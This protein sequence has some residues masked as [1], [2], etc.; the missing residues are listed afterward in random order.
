MY[1]Y[2]IK[3]FACAVTHFASFNTRRCRL[4]FSVSGNRFAVVTRSADRAYRQ[5]CRDHPTCLGERG[6][7]ERPWQWQVVGAGFMA[8]LARSKIAGE[9]HVA[10]VYW[11][12]AKTVNLE[13]LLRQLF[14]AMD[15]MHQHAEVDRGGIF[16]AYVALRQSRR[17]AAHH[18]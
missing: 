17:V 6:G 18:A 1:L 10:K 3:L 15:A 12:A 14:A 2:N 11:V 9:D 7:L 4:Q 8:R 13:R 16:S 5:R